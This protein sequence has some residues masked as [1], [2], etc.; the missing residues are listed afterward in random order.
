MSTLYNALT[1]QYPNLLS[2]IRLSEQMTVKIQGFF[3]EFVLENKLQAFVI[4]SLPT[5]KEVSVKQVERVLSIGRLA[6]CAFFLVSPEDD[7][8]RF[9]DFSFYADCSTANIPIL[10]KQ[11]VP[12]TERFIIVADERFAALMI[13]IQDSSA[14][15]YN[16]VVWT[17]NADI[18]CTA[19]QYLRGR[20]NAEFIEH[21][22]LFAAIMHRAMPKQIST[23]LTLAVTNKMAS[24]WQEQAEREVAIN[25]ITSA[26]RQSVRLDEVMTIAVKELAA[27]LD[28]ELCAIR[29]ESETE[30]Y[31]LIFSNSVIE[32]MNLEDDD[33]LAKDLEHYARLLKNVPELYARDGQKS[34]QA[35]ALPDTP[36]MVAPLIAMDKLVGILY[37]TT[38]NSTRLWRESETS[39]LQSVSDHLA[40]A[41]NQIKLYEQ[42][43]RQALTDSLTGVF[44]RRY[45]EIQIQ[46]ELK[47][48]IHQDYPISLMMI[49]LRHYKQIC[50]EWGRK[51]GDLVL[52]RVGQTIQ[53]NCRALDTVSHLGSDEFVIILPM[54]DINGAKVAAE[55]MKVILESLQVEMVGR[56]GVTIGIASHPQHAGDVADLVSAADLS[57]YMANYAE[58]GIGV[59]PDNCKAELEAEGKLIDDMLIHESLIPV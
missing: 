24:L 9:F 7:L 39:L 6:D 2:P 54:A 37:V 27:A 18:V 33:K 57:L 17:F 20:F 4:E 21:A 12:V 30:E 43:K 59:P 36:L 51:V 56:I 5:E 25:R 29:F 53:Q 23:Q 47:T 38:N 49:D 16:R 42:I 22:D 15:Y 26:I 55:R 34:L 40:T 58:D 52:R 1:N 46:R 11:S 28:V 8:N 32:E 48:A 10:L 14:T 31:P 41:I 3:E 50:D 45:F 44:N 13:A 35:T 19:L